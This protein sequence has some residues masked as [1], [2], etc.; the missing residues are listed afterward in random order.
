ME[1]YSYLYGH[2]WKNNLSDASIVLLG[3]PIITLETQKDSSWLSR[4]VLYVSGYIS[5]S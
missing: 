4:L 2:F 1:N 3:L 5:L